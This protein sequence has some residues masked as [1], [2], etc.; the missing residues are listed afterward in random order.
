METI[1]HIDLFTGLNEETARRLAPRCHRKTYEAHDPIFDMQMDATTDV[2]FIESGLVRVIASFGIARDVILGEMGPNEFF[3]ELSALDGQARS[4]SVTAV[5]RSTVTT[6][7]AAV[8][9][10][11]L[12]SDPKIALRVLRILASRVRALNTR[13]AEQSFLQ[14]RHRLYAELLRLSRPRL[15][16]DKERSISPPPTQKEL[17]ERIGTRREV[18]SRELANLQRKDIF[19][20]TRGALIIKVP[21]QLQK[22]LTE[23]WEE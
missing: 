10:E 9:V 16:S 5:Y 21:D 23:A 4:A 2:L 18:V 3:G 11:A 15:G 19:E 7:P 14:A 8:F 17:A 20:K 6:M 12:E 22:W 1:S 13:L